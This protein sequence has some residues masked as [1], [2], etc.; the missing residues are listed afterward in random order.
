MR[1][2]RAWLSRFGDVFNRHRTDRDL[3][4]ELESHLQFHIDDNLCAGMSPEEAR[5]QALLKLGGLDQTKESVRDRRGLPWLDS[6]I[7]D[8]RFALRMLRKNPGFT[9]VAILTL[10]LG[11]GANTAIF[12]LVNTV[13]LAPLPY[14]NVDRLVWVWGRSARTGLETDT[15]ISPGD[16]VEWRER[17]GIFETLVAGVDDEVT[18]TGEGNP[19]MLIGYAFSA[20]YFTALGV[21]PEL[22]RTFTEAEDRAGAPHV[23]VLSDQ[24]WRAAFYSDRTILGRSI[25]FDGDPYTVIGV[26]PPAFNYGSSNQFWVPFGPFMTSPSDYQHRFVRVLAK[27]RP[28]ISLAAAQAQMSVFAR[29]IDAEHPATDAGN[30]VSIVSLR[31]MLVGDVRTPLLVLLGAVGFVLLIACANVAGLLLARMAGRAREIAIRASLGASRIRLLQQFLTESLMLSIAG[32]LLGIV[33]AISC[34]NFL[35]AIFPNDIANLNIPKIAAVT[36]DNRVLLFALVATLL[37]S[38]IFGTV[39]ALHSSRPESE[40]L[41]E[42]GRA[43]TPGTAV[44]R[45]RRILVV[46]EISLSLVLLAGAGLLIGSF[47]R[48]ARSS[49]GFEPSHVLALE[50]FLPSNHYPSSDPIKFHLFVDKA[51][52]SLQA[53]PGVQAAGATNFLPLSGFRA[54]QGFY[55]DGKPSPQPN[56]KPSADYHLATPDYFRSMQIPL[57]RGRVFSDADQANSEQVAIVNATLVQRYLR[58]EDPLGRRLNVASPDR[59]EWWTV[60]GVVGDVKAFGPDQAAHADIYFPV[61]QAW[62]PGVAFVM[63]TA[64]DPATTLKS[65]EQAVWKVDKD[66]AIFKAIPVSALAAQAIAVRRVSMVLFAG[67]AAVALLLAA[68][69][70]YGIM[71]FAVAQRTHE[72]GVRIA[73]GARQSDILRMVLRQGMQLATIGLAIGI[74][75][76]LALTRLIRTLLFNVSATDP[77]TFVTVAVLLIAVALLACYIPAR[78]AMRVDPMIA[79]R[80]E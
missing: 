27:L 12:S 17:S 29:Q 41:K 64:N 72:I 26:M 74:L 3:A 62:F 70:I 21:P 32:G 65:A 5:R 55:V 42:S 56:R 36:V 49:L 31:Q 68:V 18:L 77:F 24:L 20:N 19:Q 40:A 50:T 13:L 60:V 46:A 71:A 43:T 75:S 66:Q 15:P 8:T 76:A 30:G 16:F 34:A 58:G 22:G 10:A 51:I 44:G 52:E 73:L 57:L 69:G 25:T 59:P 6:L 11:I 2:I 35:V 53:L 33:L 7:Y 54:L 23:V 14:K 61:D 9:T 37:T 67:F 38:I 63:R 47:E 80:H 28:G 39:P 78:R 4:A 45:A 48:V 1:T 79:L